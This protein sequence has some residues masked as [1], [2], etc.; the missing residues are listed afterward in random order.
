MHSR[1]CWLGQHRSWTT[2]NIQ[3]GHTVYTTRQLPPQILHY[4]HLTLSRNELLIFTDFSAT[5]DLHAAKLDNCS[6]DAHAVLAIFVVCHSP[7][8]VTVKQEEEDV[9]HRLNN[10]DVWYFFGNT[11]SKGKK[12]D[13]IFH[14]ASC[15][16]EIIENIQV[17]I[18]TC[19]WE[20]SVSSESM[21][22]QLCVPVHV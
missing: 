4:M 9:R 21:D 6:Q 8:F 1:N 20:G 18:P 3:V 7:R 22:R 13:H 2:G 5:C 10:C 17:A 14:D 12:N 15:L 19:W 11:I 16:K